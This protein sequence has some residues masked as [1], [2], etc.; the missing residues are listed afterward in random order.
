MATTKVVPITT[1]STSEPDACKCG[2]EGCL[3]HEMIGER[4]LSPGF[5]S[6]AA[7]KLCPNDIWVFD[8]PL[9]ECLYADGDLTPDELAAHP[10]PFLHRWRPL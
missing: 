5:T 8:H 6:E 10:G 1:S 7:M 9:T 3:G 2:D 4:I